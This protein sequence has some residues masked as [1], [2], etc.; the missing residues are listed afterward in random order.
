M[1]VFAQQSHRPAGRAW[2]Y[3]I[4]DAEGRPLCGAGLSPARWFLSE[5]RLRPLV[6]CMRCLAAQEIQGGP[7]TSKSSGPAPRLRR[8]G[9]AVEATAAALEAWEQGAMLG[10]EAEP[11]QDDD[12]PLFTP[13][14]HQ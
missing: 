4:A 5:G 8:G 3:H 12:L 1:K 13:A 7:A 10:G 9:R 6:T 14:A 2:R 11:G